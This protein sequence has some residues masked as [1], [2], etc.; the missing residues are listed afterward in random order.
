MGGAGYVGSH[1]V[2]A[3]RRRGEEVAVLDNLSTGHRAAVPA[4]IPFV[5]EDMRDER[6][7]Q[8]VFGSYS[9]TGIMHFAAH[10]LVGESVRDPAKYY[11][12]NVAGTAL[13]LD[14]ARRVAAPFVFSST[15]AVYG[16]PE[17]APVVE[18]A[19]K[20][21][22]N[23]YGRSKRMVEEMLADFHH[24]YGLPYVCLR[25]FN[26]AG[27]DRSGQI[28]EDHQPETHLFPI[29][30]RHLLGQSEQ[31]SVFGGDYDTPDGTCIRDYVHVEDLAEA[32][33]LVMQALRHKDIAAASYN[34]G[35]GRGASVL[36]VIRTA[37]KVSGRAARVSMAVRRPG[38]PAR[39]VA[40]P[41]KLRSELGFAARHSL[42]D[43][44]A[45]AWRWHRE[46]PR[47]FAD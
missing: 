15:A 42:E 8:N 35:T 32:H 6:V 45:S 13:L 9:V 33:I 47:G 29:I 20:H 3:L 25:Y 24:A 30:F 11:Q 31:V 43:V 17:R 44:A 26:A 28:G 39:L 7:L 46:R 12:N 21:P 23:P 5:C 37:E 34:V 18:D 36:E 22:V 19:P 40:S 14:Y 2:A 1:V 16:E 38:D 41:D 10:S 4:D 27:A